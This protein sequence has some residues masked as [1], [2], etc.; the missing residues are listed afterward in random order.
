MMMETKLRS[1]ITGVGSALPSRCVD[2]RELSQSIALHGGDPTTDEWMESHTGI[3][4]RYLASPGETASGLGARA[5]EMALAQAGRTAAEIDEII[6]ATTTPDHKT[7]ATANLIHHLLGCAEIPSSDVNAACT[8]F[9]YALRIADKIVRDERKRVLVVGTE[10]LS[11]I[12]DPSDRKIRVLLGDG[13]GAV[14]VEPREGTVG[15]LD[16]IVGSDGSGHA[17]IMVP[18]GGSTLP[19]TTAGLDRKLLYMQMDGGKVFK[20]ATRIIMQLAELLCARNQIQV[21][22][23]DLWVT[24]QANWR[25]IDFVMRKLNLPPERVMATVRTHGNTGTASIPIALGQAMKSG[26]LTAGKL[27]GMFGFGAGETWGAT[28]IRWAYDPS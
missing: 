5:A 20:F 21:Q 15:I 14:V 18:A 11:S 23:F 13:A 17:A 24:H 22:D 7:P 26:Q 3:R 28:L 27:V 2:N 8:G 16:V 19:V 12:A 6:V 9:V 25:I 10:V 1:V 4:T